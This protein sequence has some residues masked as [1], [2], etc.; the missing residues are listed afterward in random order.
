MKNEVAVSAR[1]AKY[2]HTPAVTH[3]PYEIPVFSNNNDLIK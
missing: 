1:F 3:T 2:E